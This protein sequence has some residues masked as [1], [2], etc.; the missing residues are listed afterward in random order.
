MEKLLLFHVN[1]TD[2]AKIKQVAGNLKIHYDLVDTTHYTQSLESLA[3]GPLHP[4]VTP[5]M[6][7]VPAESLL[8]MCDFT[9]KRMNKLLLALRKQKVQVDYKAALTQTNKKWNVLR[10]LLEMK[11]EKAAFEKQN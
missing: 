9:D 10:M 3:A 2:L 4:P 11:S 8:L 7:D 5:F 6:G 1:D